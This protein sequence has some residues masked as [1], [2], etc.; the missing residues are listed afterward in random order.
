MKISRQGGKLLAGTFILSLLAAAPCPAQSTTAASP[1]A[2][3]GVELRLNAEPQKATIGD[4]VR[5]DLDLTLPK[6]Y[7]VRLPQL[8]TQAGD[9]S[10]L[11]VFPGPT[12]PDLAP[13]PASSPAKTAGGPEPSGASHH[14][15][16]IVVA[17]YKTGELTF[18]S[19]QLSLRDPAGKESFL[20]TPPARIQIQTVLSEK[21]QNLKDLKKQAEIPEPS[22]WLLWLALGLVALILAAL[23]WWFCR[24][25]SRVSEVAFSGPQLDPLQ[26]AE[27]ELRDL[28]GR[29]LLEK[30][31]VKQF[32]VA[33]SDIVKRILEAGYGIPAIEKTTDEILEALR[34]EDSPPVPL[35]ELDSVAI[36]LGACDLVKFARCIPSQAESDQAVQ[37]AY[38]VLL[39][40][41]NRKAALTAP[42]AAQSGGGA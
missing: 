2:P 5:I 26:L 25:R 18:P 1:A 10:I 27:A 29:G 37:G 38:R 11:E 4:L 35:E 40:C 41:R 28:L 12:V 31:L 32:Y 39:L 8:G 14:H 3:P 22:R 33:L 17:A 24:R 30:S 15:A 36:F 21:D 13:S 6:G 7:Q 20:S 42:A 9:F 16:R 34:A 19:L 23:A